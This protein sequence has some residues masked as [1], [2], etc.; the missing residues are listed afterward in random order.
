MSGF[1]VASISPCS[2]CIPYATLQWLTV[3]MA[4]SNPEPS[5]CICSDLLDSAFLGSAEPWRPPNT[6]SDTDLR[7]H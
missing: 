7:R 5:L 1:A 3:A 2:C 6:I 4:L